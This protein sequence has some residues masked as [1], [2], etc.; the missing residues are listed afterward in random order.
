[1]R[2]S[3][4]SVVFFAFIISCKPDQSSQT[5]GQQGASATD[6]PM[7]RPTTQAAAAVTPAERLGD[8][9]PDYTEVAVEEKGTLDVTAVSAR[10]VAAKN[11]KTKELVN[12]SINAG[13]DCSEIIKKYATFLKSLPQDK[14]SEEQLGTL[15]TW[16]NDPLYNDCYS[17]D[18]E[19]RQ[20]ADLLEEE[21]LE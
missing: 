8:E 16:A 15:R 21:Y 14:L 5:D 1:M 18:S 6:L 19:F 9:Q 17:S 13:K 2:T 11:E 4:Y 10:E 3:I 7:A 20:A 12:Q